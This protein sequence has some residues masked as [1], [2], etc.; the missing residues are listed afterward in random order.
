MLTTTSTPPSSLRADLTNEAT[1]P[2]SVTSHFS[3]TTLTPSLRASSATWFSSFIFALVQSARLAP[4]PANASAAA[5]PMLRLAP[6]MRTF[7]PLRPVSIDYAALACV[8]S[9]PGMSK[10]SFFSPSMM[11]CTC[12]AFNSVS[13]GRT[14]PHAASS[15]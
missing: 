12:T 5:L 4:S 14:A 9:R 1:A 15:E 6:V 7:L 11:L 10:S 3:A 8:R 2:A 13:G